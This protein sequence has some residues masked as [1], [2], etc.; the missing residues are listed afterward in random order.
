MTQGFYGSSETARWSCK[1]SDLDRIGLGRLSVEG[2]WE[3][4]ELKVSIKRPSNPSIF[5][6]EGKDP[7]EVLGVFVL[8]GPL[9]KSRSWSLKKTFRLGL[10][11]QD[12]EEMTL[13]PD[14]PGE[15]VKSW[16]HLSCYLTRK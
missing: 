11:Q 9:L 13:F 1:A 3:F 14:T 7:V 15:A 8:F 16:R 2:R 12:K 6:I 4:A 10:G 5:N